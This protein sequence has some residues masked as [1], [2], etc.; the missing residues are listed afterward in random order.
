[1]SLPDTPS[2]SGM[3][4]SSAGC[5]ATELLCAEEVR[6]DCDVV[7]WPLLDQ[8]QLVRM[9]SSLECSVSSG[10]PDASLISVACVSAAP[11]CDTPAR[12]DA[13]DVIRSAA[14]VGLSVVIVSSGSISLSASVA[15][16]SLVNCRGFEA[17]ADAVL[18]W[19]STS[20]AAPVVS[21]VCSSSF[22]IVCRSRG[23]SESVRAECSGLVD[24]DTASESPPSMGKLAT[25]E[26]SNR[27]R[28][29]TVLMGERAPVAGKVGGVDIPAG[30]P[31][32]ANEGDAASMRARSACAET[33]WRL[34][35]AESRLDIWLTAADTG[36]GSVLDM[37]AGACAVSF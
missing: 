12:A 16:T 19:S 30:E 31:S 34:D 25:G 8:L 26:C 20:R 22:G 11:S 33:V 15:G 32:S 29:A 6:P 35:A 7:S 9:L 13:R 37:Q 2:A 36:Q 10:M 23:V 27:R 28:G 1:M 18:A 14:L 21:I 4:A 3:P 17:T 5:T 24:S